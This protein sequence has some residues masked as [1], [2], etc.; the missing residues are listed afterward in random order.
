MQGR[1]NLRSLNFPPP[2]SQGWGDLRHG[3]QPQSPPVSWFPW[4]R[5]RYP[6]QSLDLY[7]GPWFL[8]LKP[9][10]GSLSFAA[11]EMSSWGSTVSP[12]LNGHSS[13]SLLSDASPNPGTISASL[14]SDAS[15]TPDTIS[16]TTRMTSCYCRYQPSGS[17]AG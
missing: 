9:T 14:F 11:K 3:V 1:Q 13:A 6:G 5:F 4:L 10:L 7:W 17:S 12:F 15:P 2:P 8:Q 16:G